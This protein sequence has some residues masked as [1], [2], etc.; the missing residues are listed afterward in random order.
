LAW[1]VA[2]SIG[3]CARVLLRELRE[4]R[5]LVTATGC[6]LAAVAALAAGAALATGAWNATTAAIPTGIATA[7]KLLAALRISGDKW[8]RSRAVRADPRGPAMTDMPVAAEL[9]LTFR[10]PSGVGWCCP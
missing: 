10:H 2:G 7:A 1:L 6:V 8:V 4:L 9:R 5:E 3:A